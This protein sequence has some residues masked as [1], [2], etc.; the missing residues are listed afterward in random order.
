M[1]IKLYYTIASPPVRAVILTL[2][3]LDIPYEP[4]E[5]NLLQGGHRSE[6]FLKVS[7]T[8]R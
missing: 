8:T 7:F 2:K 6:E 1:A 4:K 5:I 3:A